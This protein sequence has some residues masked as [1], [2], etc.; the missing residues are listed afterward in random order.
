MSNAIIGT[1]SIVVVDV[2]PQVLTL[3]GINSYD[4]GTAIRSGTLRVETEAA[5]GATTALDIGAPASGVTGLAASASALSAAV[6]TYAANPT[7]ANATAL[8]EAQGAYRAVLAGGCT[9]GTL[10]T[11]EIT[12]AT[13]LDGNSDVRTVIG[14]GAAAAFHLV[15]KTAP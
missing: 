1:G 7:T 2:G 15:G 11:L 10:P 6:S 9:A 8:G 5:L 13:V 3:P 14:G 4:G 12:G